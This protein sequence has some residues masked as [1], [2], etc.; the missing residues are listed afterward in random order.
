MAR[1]HRHFNGLKLV[2]GGLLAYL[3]SACSV[4]RINGEHDQIQHSSAAD[5]EYASVYFIRPTTEHVQGFPDN[6]LKVFV[7][8]ELLMEL[9]KGEYTL[10]RLKPQTNT[11]ITTETL[12]QTRG[13][14]EVEPIR[15]T[16]YFDFEANQTYYLVTR[17]FD[18][19]FRGVKFTPE[20]IPLA[21]ARETVRYLTAVGA[22]EEQPIQ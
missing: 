22:A 21:D 12:T 14:W 8:D 6:P 15:Q 19:E 7:N 16:R 5:A 13:R 1:Q 9:G 18:G 20:L 11:K 10:V 3:L 4:T 17:P 2:L